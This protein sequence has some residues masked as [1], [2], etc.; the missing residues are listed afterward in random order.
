M[1]DYI[2]VNQE[3]GNTSVSLFR[4]FSSCSISYQDLTHI[5]NYTHL[6]KYQNMNW[7]LVTFMPCGMKHA[8]NKTFGYVSDVLK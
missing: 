6:M 5:N 7:Y 1:C 3:M 8:V 2:I 4:K